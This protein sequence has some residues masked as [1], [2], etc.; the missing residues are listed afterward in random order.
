MGRKLTLIKEDAERVGSAVMEVLNLVA[1]LLLSVAAAAYLLRENI[2]FALPLGVVLLS[3]CLNLKIARPGVE[4]RYKTE[5][6]KEEQYKHE[7]GAVIKCVEQ[8]E[9]L[10]DALLSPLGQHLGTS[11]M[12]GFIYERWRLFVAF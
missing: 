5:L 6:E 3:V 10:D 12:A 9:R 7:L 4:S 8:G 11:V 1:S 2:H